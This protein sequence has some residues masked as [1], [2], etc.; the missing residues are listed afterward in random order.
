[1]VD[2]RVNKLVE[3]QDDA[4]LVVSYYV[5]SFLFNLTLIIE[6]KEQELEHSE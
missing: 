1:M 4:V 2:A 6:I 3:M 5:P